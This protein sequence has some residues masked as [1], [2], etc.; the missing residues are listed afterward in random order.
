M[1]PTTTAPAGRDAAAAHASITARPAI[2]RP[3]TTG[4]AT[5][6]APLISAADRSV[7]VTVRIRST[8]TPVQAFD[9][10]VPID[11]SLVFKKWG[12]IPGVRGVDNQNGAWDAAGKSRNPQLTDGSTVTERLTEYTPGHSFAYEITDFTGPLR[13]LVA[14]ARGEWTFT[15]DGAATMITWT[16][17]FKAVSG[18]SLLLKWGLAPVW[19]RYMRRAATNTARAAEHIT[20][21]PV[22]A[23]PQWQ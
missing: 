17:E 5:V 10:I 12:L 3:R 13:H 8:L 22:S 19:R 16:Y 14:G 2:R 15:P 4:Q 1:T 23:P 9:I 21:D 20:A 7:P 6:P 18:R 11:L